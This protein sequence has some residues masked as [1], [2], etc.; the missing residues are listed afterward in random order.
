[1]ATTP[2]ISC[3]TPGTFCNNW[4]YQSPAMQRYLLLQLLAALGVALN[5]IDSADLDTIIA[6]AAAWK[7]ASGNDINRLLQ[8]E[9]LTI[10]AELP[11]VVTTQPTCIDPLDL[12]A[13]IAYLICVLSQSTVIIT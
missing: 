12:E 11:S 3:E 10:A 9:A 1:M 7:C 6:S 5:A 4:V 8:M 2:A 13:A